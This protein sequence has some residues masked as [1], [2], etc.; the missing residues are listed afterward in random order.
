MNP[1][2]YPNTNNE[3]P[4]NPI[5]VNP[6]AINPITI[7]PITIN[8]IAKIA[9]ELSDLFRGAGSVIID[10][11]ACQTRQFNGSLTGDLKCLL[12]S[13]ENLMKRLI[14][15]ATACLA[16]I[17]SV[18]SLSAQTDDEKFIL[19][20]ETAAQRQARMAWWKE[21]RFGMFV[22]WGLYS[23]T[24]G[25]WGEKKFVRGAEWIQRNAGVSA[26]EYE[27]TMR[28]KFKPSADFAEQW[29]KLAKR[30]G[31]KYVVYT[32]KHHEGFAMH[33]SAETEFDAKD[34]TGRDLH[35]EIVEAIRGEGLRVGLYHSL[36]DWHHPD[37]PAGKGAMN[38]GGL[39]MDDRD[40]SRYTDY[41][42]A[43]V[44]EITDGRYGEVDVL[45]LDYSKNQFQ[46]EAWRAKELV[47][48]LRKNQPQVLINNRLWK[49]TKEKRD[50]Q[51]KYWFGDFSTP[52]QHIPA[53]GI[54]GVDWETC[55]TLNIT[56]GWS[57]H[58]TEYKTST[59]LIHRLIDAVSKGGNYLL[60]VGPLP[61][62]SI[63]PKSV[64]RFN[65]I[66][67]W[68]KVNGEAIYGT[69]AS[70][71]TRLPWGRATA[72]QIEGGYRLYLHVFDWPDDGRLFIPGLEGLPSQGQI[73]G[74]PGIQKKP[75][76]KVR[77][78]ALIRGLP[79]RPKNAAADAATVIA[80]DFD[81]A[82]VVA[83]YRVYSA[84]DGAFKLEPADASVKA[85]K[86]HDNEMFQRSNIDSWK[87]DSSATYPLQVE[88][89]GDYSV[90]AEIATNRLTE[91][92]NFVLSAGGVEH[93]CVVK[94]T[95]GPKKWKQLSL[96]SIK[97]PEGKVEL[98]LQCKSIVNKG[99]VKIATMSLK[100][101]Q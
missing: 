21:A 13:L 99:V 30:A 68:M 42:H 7:N 63:D 92:A 90:E 73:F 51:E 95:G 28:P 15:L 64:E 44:N 37:A 65:A 100:P 81:E 14:S 38:L 58:A 22:H 83:P 32:N 55:D 23:S 40:L 82:P 101:A 61:D 47:E 25:E 5:A 80:L 35:K 6:I 17:I 93:P 12:S 88:K 70:P 77:G 91:D 33:D 66:G 69:Q 78:G 54:E 84:A 79:P 56:W 74:I 29:A 59:E 53:N 34:F 97:L 46:G 9:T 11:E 85:A 27:K 41:L 87:A 3:R 50:G 94:P 76:S 1:N 24:E 16:M 2:E 18:G 98:R 60:N 31:V 10:T 43:Q 67:D 48:L 26:D 19:D 57:K 8:P 45:W 72:K 39:S 49:N 71:F 36:W 96:G 20:T 86:Y 4:P 89:A 75:A 62:G 52:E